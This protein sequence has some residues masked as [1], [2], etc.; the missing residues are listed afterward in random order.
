MDVKSEIFAKKIIY[1]ALYFYFN[2]SYNNNNNNKSTK[3]FCKRSLKS[4]VTLNGFL[5]QF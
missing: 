4:H 1:L 2:N 3:M 5:V